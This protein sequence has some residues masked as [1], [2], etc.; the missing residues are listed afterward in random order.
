MFFHSKTCDIWNIFFLMNLKGCFSYLSLKK[1]F[2]KSF[3][4]FHSQFHLCMS[5]LVVFP[6]M[7]KVLC[8]FLDR[9]TYQ[10]HCL[11]ILLPPILL[12]VFPVFQI[13]NV[14]L[15]YLVKLITHT[16]LNV[17]MPVIIHLSLNHLNKFFYHRLTF[18][19]KLSGLIN[20]LKF[21]FLELPSLF[22]IEA[23]K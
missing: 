1:D 3:N 14:I 18:F 17:P 12:S 19:V 8:Q 22:T 7:C 13:V 23:A 2:D 9:S 21:F 16:S 4:I 20:V 15:I 11:M 10:W 5:T 6:S